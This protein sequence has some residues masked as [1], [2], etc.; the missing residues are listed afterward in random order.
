MNGVELDGRTIRVRYDR[1]S[2][3]DGSSSS[4]DAKNSRMQANTLY[5]QNLA[6]STLSEDLQEAFR[7]CQGYKDAFVK[8]DKDDRPAGYGFV[9]F[10]SEAAAMAAE[11]VSKEV[12]RFILGLL[13]NAVVVHS[14]MVSGADVCAKGEG[15]GHGPQ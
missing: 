13:L 9:R 7:S 14:Q 1:P 10:T 11:A 5:V 8:F 3:T 12:L 15:L 4:I 2:R 6:W